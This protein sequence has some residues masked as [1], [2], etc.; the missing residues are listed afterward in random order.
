MAAVDPGSGFALCFGTRPQVIK[1]S[2][3]RSVLGSRWPV[4]TVDTGQHYDYELNGLLYEQLSVPR[5]DHFLEVGSGPAAAQTAAVL[6]RTAEVLRAI[7]PVAVV[8]I[9]DTNSTVGC[10]LAATKEGLPLVHVEAGLRSNEPDLPEESNRRIV[11][12]IG[13]LLCAPSERCAARLR[14]E[15][16]PGTVVTTGDVARDVLTRSL[17]L[18]PPPRPGEPFALVTIHRAALTGDAD[19]F[20]TVLEALGDLGLPA[21]FPVHPRTRAALERFDLLSCVPHSV[22]LRSP[23]GY[24]ETI[25]AARDAAVVVTDS[26]GLQREAYWLGTPC[27]TLRCETEWVETVECG[28]NVLVPPMSAPGLLAETVAQ[29]RQREC[30]WA[31]DAYGDGHAAQKVAD[32]AA[33]YLGLS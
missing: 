8:V 19:A 9:G 29:Q 26:G 16:V 28:A 31:R 7:R 20:R 27:V 32:A 25:A 18:A 22:S 23:M 11:D 4:T 2:I 1:A 5:P 10:A 17:T 24:L 13:S 15:G 3:L 30:S 33:L 6:A 21:I 12:V 14:A